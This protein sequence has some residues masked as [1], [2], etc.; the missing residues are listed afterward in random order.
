MLNILNFIQNQASF[1]GVASSLS[2]LWCAVVQ[3]QHVVGIFLTKKKK[4][5]HQIVLSLGLGPSHN[6]TKSVLR[7]YYKHSKFIRS[8][9]TTSWIAALQ[10]THKQFLDNGASNLIRLQTMCTLFTCIISTWQ[11]GIKTT[12][13]TL[14]DVL[15]QFIIL[16]LI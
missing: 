8:F 11:V 6:G 2:I 13:W 3:Q 16:E 7:L 10:I 9:W 12:V 1:L 5:L 15:S 4:H 14:H